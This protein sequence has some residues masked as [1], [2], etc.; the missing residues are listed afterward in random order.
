[1]CCED[2]ENGVQE[3]VDDDWKDVEAKEE[4]FFKDL[5][6]GSVKLIDSFRPKHIPVDVSR[7]FLG[8]NVS[9]S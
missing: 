8:R 5:R 6:K 3:T 9:C 1:M 4:P 2:L 7:P